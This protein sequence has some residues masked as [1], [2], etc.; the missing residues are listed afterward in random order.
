MLWPKGSVASTT[1]MQPRNLPATCSVTKTP[2]L[3]IKTSSCGAGLKA[4]RETALPTDS[5]AYCRSLWRSSAE[6]E[7]LGGNGILCFF[8]G[9]FHRLGHAQFSARL[10][11]IVE[12]APEPQKILCGGNQRADYHQPPQYQSQRLER[13]MARSTDQHRDRANL[14]NHLRFAKRGGRDRQSLG[15]SNVAQTQHCKPPAD[16]NYHHTAWYELHLYKR[17]KSR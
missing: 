8:R 3:R 12:L 13:R 2:H 9:R 11:P 5:R 16:N 17:N 15:R 10:D 4:E 1:P 14:Q 6:V 7:S